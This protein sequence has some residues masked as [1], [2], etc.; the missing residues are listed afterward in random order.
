MSAASVDANAAARAAAAPGTGAQPDAAAMQ[1]AAQ[2]V[3]QLST[4][5]VISSAL[6]VVVKL[7]IPDRLAAGAKTAGA[8]AHETG[9][10]EDALYRVLRALAG[11]GL[12][13]EDE[14]QRFTLTLPS[15]LLRTDVPGSMAP[16]ASW[17]CDPFHFKIHTEFMHS[18]RTGQP[19]IEKVFGKPI[20][21]YFPDDPEESAVF[22]DA[23][24]TFSASVI[25]AVLEA[26]DF[27]GIKLLVDVAGGHGHVLTSILQK[28]PSMRGLLLD[29][30]HVIAGA[31]PLIAQQ[32]VTD[33]CETG[34]V[35]FFAAVPACGDAYIMKHI[36]HDWDDAK[37]LVILRHIRAALEG[38]AGGRLILLEGIVAPANQPDFAKVLDIEMLLMPGGRERTEAEFRELL[39]KGGFEFT[40]VVPTASPLCVIEACPR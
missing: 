27:S 6:N 19:A 37:A 39:R 15:T 38:Q 36:I 35:D 25:P 16:L 14:L 11:V 7:G 28:Y 26:Y 18:V 1:A 4:G 8:L 2:Q 40:R 17:F 22:N 9:V 5:Y 24:T 30:D 10:N 13:E 21:E 29:L 31:G 34:L 23:M 20:F 3:I 32:G 12:F 33:R